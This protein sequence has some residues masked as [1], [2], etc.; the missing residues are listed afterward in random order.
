VSNKT[1]NADLL[2]VDDEGSIT[3]LGSRCD[4]CS[5]TFFGRRQFCE[6]CSSERM[7]DVDL[8]LDGT[9]HSATVVRYPPPGD[10]RD[11]TRQ[12]PFNV[13]LIE[14]P[15]GVLIL[16]QINGIAVGAPTQGLVVRAMA[17]PAYTDDDGDPVFSYAF[18]PVN[19]AAQ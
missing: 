9:V 19:G 5:E 14:M 6:Y 18:T 12:A 7:S 15:E 10:Y 8:S 16:G 2:S 3:L 13:G 17:R 11:A 4:D 1:V